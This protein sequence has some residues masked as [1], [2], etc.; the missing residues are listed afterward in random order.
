MISYLNGSV[1]LIKA[2]YIIVEVNGVGYKVHVSTPVLEQYTTGQNIELFTHQYV[3]DDAI[4][5][6]GF[7]S[8]ARLELFEKFISVSGI[9]PK[10]GIALLSQFSV[11]E[12]QQSIL[13]GDTS[14]LTKV[15]GIGKKTAERLILELKGT[16]GDALSD[17]VTNQSN[18]SDA[19]NA[20]EQ[21]GYSSHEA[22]QALK[23]V[24]RSLSVEEQI[25][26]ALTNLGKH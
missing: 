25:K 12:L 15:S 22:L 17:D 20:L 18:I 9:G 10:A 8:V 13:S 4:D 6:Y 5:L 3:R 26:T 19:L 1:L 16:L 11:E 2:T 21:L 24:D 23:T 14:L 7:L